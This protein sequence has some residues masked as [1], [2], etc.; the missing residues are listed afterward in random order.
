M[1]F[2]VNDILRR[3]KIT[4]PES[5]RICGKVRAAQKLVRTRGRKRED[6][7]GKVTSFAEQQNELVTAQTVSVLQSN[8]LRLERANAQGTSQ[9][10]LL[11]IEY[12]ETSTLVNKMQ[13]TT[14]KAKVDMDKLKQKK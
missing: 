7:L 12:N 14:D 8:I 1:H 11:N 5:R 2:Y 6:L 13:L 4:V 10:A 3:F 9:N